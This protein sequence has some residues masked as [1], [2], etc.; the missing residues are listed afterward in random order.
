MPFIP[1]STSTN[2]LVFSPDH[3]STDATLHQIVN[4]P[5]SQS[6]HLSGYLTSNALL[7]NIY[8]RRSWVIQYLWKCFW[9]VGSALAS[10][11]ALIAIHKLI[12]SVS[13]PEARTTSFY[14]L[15]AQQHLQNCLWQ[16]ASTVHSRRVLDSSLR[17]WLLFLWQTPEKH[18]FDL[19]IRKRC[20]W[21]SSCFC[22]LDPPVHMPPCFSEDGSWS[23]ILSQKIWE[24]MWALTLA[25]DFTQ[26]FRKNILNFCIP[27]ALYCIWT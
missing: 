20:A 23:H 25:T 14:H 18:L 2:P 9:V 27:K 22:F 8:E 12:N 3:L 24:W 15:P 4:T 7:L 17:C 21:F 1:S 6:T 16:D 5:G 10:L 11:N 13:G 26:R 19:S